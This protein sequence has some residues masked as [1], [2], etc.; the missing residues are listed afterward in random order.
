M[1]YSTQFDE[2]TKEEVRSRIDIA[3]VVGR[4]VKLRSAGRNMAGLCPF[5][6]DTDPSFT[7]NPER[8]FFHCFGCGKGG[9]VFT[10]V[11]DIEG[12]TFPEALQVLADEAGVALKKPEHHAVQ[13][14]AGTPDRRQMLRIHEIAAAF[15][16]RQIKQHPR[17]VD[18]FKARGLKPQTVREFNLGFAPQGWA[19]L[20]SFARS[21]GIGERALIH[22]GLAVTK[23]ESSSAYDRFRNRIMFPLTDLTGK[24]IA[25]AGRSLDSETMPKYLNSPET[26]LYRKSKTLYGLHKARDV[27]KELDTVYIVEGYMDYLALYEAG[28]FNCAATSGTALTQEH[29][30]ILRRFTSNIT[31]VFDGDNAGRSAAEKAFFVLAPMSLDISV[32]LLPQGEDP[33]TYVR[34]HGAEE[35]RAEVARAQNGADFV[36]EKAMHDLQGTTPRGQAAVIAHLRPV[37]EGFRDQLFRQA[38]IKKLAEH[39]TVDEKIIYGRIKQQGLRG[40]GGVVSDLDPTKNYLAT[41]EGNFLRLI[42]QHPELIEKAQEKIGPESFTD[43]FSAKLY[44]TVLDAYTAGADLLQVFTD[45]QDTDAKRILSLISVAEV[46]DE[47]AGEELDHSLLRLEEKRLRQQLRSISKQI[48]RN[49]QNRLVLLQEQMSLT[50]RLKELVSPS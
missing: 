1:N 5:H 27:V 36:I 42:V 7:V 45:V 14:P 23:S 21:H 24:T 2:T 6:K 35:M 4:Y 30:H 10:F 15:Y 32:L 26:P 39:L 18:Y 9:D 37:M 47:N 50:Q 16:Y 34:A 44:L 12:M 41:L 28:I 25:F 19:H 33:D 43:Q 40:P 17:A 8:G 29:A 13:A 20:V 31:L 38:F 11:Q 22:C 3:S 48:S 49:P 46:A